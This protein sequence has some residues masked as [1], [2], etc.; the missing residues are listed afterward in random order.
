MR[1]YDR[2]LVAAAGT[3]ADAA[4]FKHAAL[5]AALLPAAHVHLARVIDPGL[6]IAAQRAVQQT[7]AAVPAPLA[8]VAAA[9]RLTVAAHGGVPLDVLLHEAELVQSDLL[10]VGESAAGA[11]RRPLARRLAMKAP[12]SVWM[13][14]AGAPARLE[15]LLVPVDLSPRS[16]DALTVA[17][18]LAAAAGIARC[19]VLHVHFDAALSGFDEYRDAVEGDEQRALALFAARVDLHRVALEPLFVES[20]D[21][22]AAIL[23]TAAAQRSD[24]I[25][26]GTRGR[27]TAA[28]AVLGS[29]TDHVLMHS[30]VPVLAVKHFGASLRFRDALHDR[31]RRGRGPKFS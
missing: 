11:G 27:S 12:C 4:V 7:I 8:A 29:E 18:A 23:R 21:V 16:A 6:S 2:V 25:V 13:L 10:L 5:L 30:P 1:R 14:P 20:G 26:M 17:T 3:P 9:G 28:A 15:R 31:R 19:P 22:T 24:L